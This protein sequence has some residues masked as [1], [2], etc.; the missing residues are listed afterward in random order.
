MPALSHEAP[1]GTLVHGSSTTGLV[2]PNAIVQLSVALRAECGA[3]ACNRIMTAAGLAD[4]VEAPPTQLIP[5]AEAA[6]LFAATRAALPSA[7]ADAVLAAAGVLTADYVLANRIPRAAQRMLRLLP[8]WLSAR[9]FLGAIKAHAWTFAGSGVVTI[10]TGRHLAMSIAD[11]PL[12]TPGCPWHCAVLERLFQRTVTPTAH[13]T[14][15]AAGR[16]DQFRI[17]TPARG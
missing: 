7:R 15:G 6:R 2:G 10:D 16:A 8:V 1:P 17:E 12:A 3:D 14:H 4:Y 9:A 5:E 13:V 11:N